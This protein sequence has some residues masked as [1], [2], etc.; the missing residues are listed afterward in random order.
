MRALISTYDKTGIDV[1]A[2]GLVEIEQ[3]SSSK[4]GRDFASLGAEQQTALLESLTGSARRFFSTVIV[5]TMQGYYGD[6]RH[7][8]AF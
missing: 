3:A 5:H 2:R 8:V 7:G 4:F 1:F 6:P